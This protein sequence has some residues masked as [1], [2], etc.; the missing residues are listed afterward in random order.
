MTKH[1]Y[2]C[3]HEQYGKIKKD[4]LIKANKIKLL[5]SDVDGVMSN[6]LIY[7][8]N[9]KEYKSFHVRDNY[10]IKCLISS[11]I[12]VAI[13]SGRK[14]KSVE[15]HCSNLGIKYFYL[16]KLN[17]LES[18]KDIKNKLCLSLEEIAYIGD[19]FIDLPILSKVG[20]SIAVSNS[21]PILLK[22]VDYITNNIGGYGAIREIC[23]IILYS[24]KKFDFLKNY[25]YD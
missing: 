18:F 9:N 22:K 5:I 14:S 19:D 4:I 23:D 1:I 24:Q 16:G 11:C 13:I 6:G 12:E 25:F 17:K 7:L 10:G 20:L 15:T 3:F 8:K 2:D 21:H